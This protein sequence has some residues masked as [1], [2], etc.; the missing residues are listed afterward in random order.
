MDRKPGTGR[1]AEPGG[2]RLAEAA[3]KRVRGRA[4]VGAVGEHPLRAVVAADAGDIARPPDRAR[5]RGVPARHLGLR[6]PLRPRGTP[7]RGDAVA[8]RRPRVDPGRALARPEVL[9]VP[10]RDRSA[11]RRPRR[12]APTLVRR[13][14]R[15][16]LRDR[17]R[18]RGPSPV[19]WSP[20]R[21]GPPRR[22]AGPPRSARP[23]RRPPPPVGGTGTIARRGG[24]RS[25]TPDGRRSILFET[26]HPGARPRTRAPGARARSRWTAIPRTVAAFEGA[27]PKGNEGPRERQRT[28]R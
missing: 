15:G 22:T 19:A 17:T 16:A 1:P 4:R 25:P 27:E 13:R 24:E 3:P 14:R 20:G 26:P 10:S 12:P 18:E 9:R 21:I 7:E 11:G 2:S 28:G 23:P 6:E 8:R 5:Q